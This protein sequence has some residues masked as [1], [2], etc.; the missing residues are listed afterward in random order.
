MRPG[1]LFSAACRGG[2]TFRSEDGPSG[3]A[4][5]EAAAVASVFAVISVLMEMVASEVTLVAEAR[6][7]ELPALPGRGSCGS[8]LPSEPKAPGED[9]VGT[10]S[11]SPAAAQA[12]EVVEIPSNDEA[13]VSAEPSVPLWQPTGDVTVEPLVPS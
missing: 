13:D 10:G 9:V 1:S 7:T 5:D 3:S 6:D 8:P 11:G 4:V 12:N 2:K